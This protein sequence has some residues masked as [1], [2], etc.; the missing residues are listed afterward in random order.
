M[1]DLVFEIENVINQVCTNEYSNARWDENNIS[2]RLVEGLEKTLNGREINYVHF[3]K[4]ISFKAYKQSGKSETNYGDIALLVN[5]HFSSVEI[6]KGVAFLEAKRLF[7]SG[8]FESMDL[9]QLDRLKTNVPYAQVLQ[10]YPNPTEF[11]LKFPFEW[12]F[13]SC[14]WVSPV[15]T[16]HELLKQLNDK[17]NHRII[18]TSFP[19]SQFFTGRILWGKDLDFREDLY[20]EVLNAV[21]TRVKP[22]Y[23]CVLDTYYTD[24]R[25]TKTEVSD[26]WQKIG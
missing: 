4:K 1:R 25:P 15:N 12:D 20:N 6:L 16:S 22:Q 19:L 3:R 14:M 18:R 23:L 21:G 26:Y 13:K 5:I 17:D 2:F 8:Y 9:N 11:L 7:N 10:Y 24:Q